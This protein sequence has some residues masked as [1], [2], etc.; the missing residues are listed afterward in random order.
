MFE[1]RIHHRKS[2]NFIRDA[3]SWDN[4]AAKKAKEA[5]R[6][7]DAAIAKTSYGINYKDIHANLRNVKPGCRS[8]R[9][10]F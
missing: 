7:E 8:C 6:V 3:N 4:E 10:T 1:F 2:A 5:V 9:G